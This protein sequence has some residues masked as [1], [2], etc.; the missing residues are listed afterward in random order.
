MG[1][2]SAELVLRAR[3]RDRPTAR[4]PH[5]TGARNQ[6]RPAAGIELKAQADRH[7]SRIQFNEER[8]RNST[9]Q[10]ARAIEI[11]QAEERRTRHRP[12][13]CRDHCDRITQT[14]ARSPHHARRSRNVDKP[15]CRA[16]KGTTERQQDPSGRPSPATLPPP[17][18][19]PAS[20]TKSTPSTSRSRAT[21]SG[22][23]NCRRKN[24]TRRGAHPPGNA[25]RPA[26]PPT[27]R[28]KNA[29]SPIPAR[30]GRGAARPACANSKQ[31]LEQAGAELDELVQQQAGT[32]LPARRPRTAC[33]PTTRASAPARSPP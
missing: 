28:P 25:D 17:R 31:R 32:P 4:T 14:E 15:P 16:S 7:E 27:S 30:L 23:K 26:S 8:L 1:Q 9:T 6:R 2:S 11:A 33:N 18:T 12:G 5:R 29:R 10:N 20:A 21:S 22:W 13:T 19:W 24:P 3:R